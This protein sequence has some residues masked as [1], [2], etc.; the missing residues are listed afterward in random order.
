MVINLLKKFNNYY[1]R[2]IKK[3]STISDYLSHSADSYSIDINFNPNDGVETEQII[4]NFGK[5][6]V[7]DYAVITTDNGTIKSR[8]FVMECTRTRGG[9]YKI[10]LRR[11]VIADNLDNLMTSKIFVQKGTITDSDSKL[12]YNSEN[13][14][15][16]QIKKQEILLKDIS[17]CPWLVLYLKKNALASHTAINVG[18][19]LS[20]VSYVT[21]PAK[22]SWS[23]INNSNLGLNNPIKIADEY[24]LRFKYKRVSGS[25]LGPVY[26][27]YEDSI[28]ATSTT[29]S[30][31][32]KEHFITRSLLESAIRSSFEGLVELGKESFNFSDNE[33]LEQLNR[34]V[35]LI[36]FQDTNEYYECRLTTQY[37]GNTFNR[38]TSQQGGL[39]TSL[40]DIW[41]NANGSD[42]TA[43]DHAFELLSKHEVDYTL[44]LVQREDLQCRGYTDDITTYTNSSLYDIICAPYGDMILDEAFAFDAIHSSASKS[45]SVM[46]SIAKQL[47]G[48]SGNVL[49]YQLIPYCPIRQ[50][51]SGTGGRVIMPAG[52]YI[53]FKQG[54]DE[55]YRVFIVKE[56]NTSFNILS[57]IGIE[58][59]SISELKYVN[60]C[61][62]MRLCS[63]NYNGIFEFNLA[64]NGGYIDLFNVD[65]TLKPY[66]VYIHVN[67]NFSN[68]YGQDYNDARGL[69]CGGDFSLGVQNDAWQSYQLQNKNYQNIFDRQIQSMD[70]ENGIRRV[71][72]GFGIGAGTVQGAVGGAMAGGMIGGGYGAAAGAIIGGGTSLA[73][74]IVDMA[75]LEKRI[76]EQRNLAID[77]F[78]M[79]LGNVKALPI[80]VSKTDA[81]TANNKLYPFLEIYEPTDIEKE[82]YMR[83]L[84]YDGMT[85]GIIDEL[86]NWTDLDQSRYIKG[87]LIRCTNID[88]ENHM[89]ET[90]G[91]ELSKGIYL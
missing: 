38:I 61:Q 82:A 56:P 40:Q 3:Y 43:N 33:E 45:K 55:L 78:N 32:L 52:N 29:S 81:L 13:Y 49:D 15:C 34:Y 16:N 30:T 35:G 5:D 71:E 60:D 42:T 22:N 66:N 51:L 24:A 7:P 89:L 54:D 67:P 68:L 74:G 12:I 65:M 64:K 36:Y 53:S 73:G 57:N 46:D 31:N 9:Q 47:G 2:I 25:D 41:N 91:A 72:A 11:D 85:I 58:N 62:M 4:Q 18:N 80:S 87:Q 10:R 77:N 23:Y 26:D 79:Q 27:V 6:I 17:N 59:N 84:E 83:K 63:P 19:E 44:F 20:G 28:Q 76:T 50:S 90:I 70:R 1:N 88:D 8:W 86:Q 37:K 48:T 21:I 14:N 69:I 39:K 75:N